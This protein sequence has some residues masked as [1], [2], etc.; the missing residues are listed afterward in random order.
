VS[1][2]NEISIPALSLLVPSAALALIMEIRRRRR[3]LPKPPKPPKMDTLHPKMPKAPKAPLGAI[4][5]LS[6][7]QLLRLASLLPSKEGS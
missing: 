3:V 2:I 6:L 7:E 4:E 1:T 5:E